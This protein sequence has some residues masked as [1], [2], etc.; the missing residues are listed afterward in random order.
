MSVQMEGLSFDIDVH[1]SSASKELDNLATSLSNIQNAIGKGIRL[2]AS[3]NS[4]KKLSEALKGVNPDS[5]RKLEE[6]GKGLKSLGENGRIS[7]S[8][9][10]PKRI[11]ELATAAG[12]ITTDQIVNLQLLATAMERI[13][14]SGATKI[15]RIRL[16]SVPTTIQKEETPKE[17]TPKAE[18]PANDVQ[19]FGV[20]D[21]SPETAKLPNLFD[22][23]RI[24][25][26][27]A[28]SKIKELS[29]GLLTLGKEAVAPM[30]KLSGGFIKN[31]ALLPLTLGSRLAGQIK[32]VTLVMMGSVMCVFTHV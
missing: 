20:K 5:V 31:M 16:D 1:A 10:L 27:G 17:E 19:T 32:N 13:G 21:V 25:A 8:A 26:G 14:A 23:I 9:A 3:T 22:R 4:I 2:T 11:T 12:N 15:P 28:A 6:L 18:V 7:I 24:S 30:A 29:G